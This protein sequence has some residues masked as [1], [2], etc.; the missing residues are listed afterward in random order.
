LLLLSPLLA[1]GQSTTADGIRALAEGD[2]RAALRILGPLADAPDP[3]PLAQFFLGA[4]YDTNSGVPG[5][6][7]RACGLYLKSARSANPLASE[8][9]ALAAMIRGDNPFISAVCEAS[10]NLGE[11]LPA[12]FILGPG[13]SVI[14]DATGLTIAYRGTE[15][16]I[17]TDWSALGF[18]FLPTKYSRLEVTRPVP[19]T[20][21]FIEVW[22]WTPDDPPRLT[23]WRLLWAVYEV[24]GD[25][26]QAIWTQPVVAMSVSASQP[27]VI[28]TVDAIGRVQ[29]NAQ[30]EAEQ[31]VFGL[32]A[33]TTVIPYRG[34][35]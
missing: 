17:P 5:D 12:T 9:I 21:H 26:A 30:G 1:A 15:R 31:T 11:P 13:H 6:P 16:R 32:N 4:L 22:C 23:S 7:M 33:R 2:T 25:M 24:T 14:T 27:P 35:R 8:A 28:R 18:V 34:A 20:R 29:I 3:D 10:G 19:A